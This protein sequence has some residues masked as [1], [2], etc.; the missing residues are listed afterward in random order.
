METKRRSVIKKMAASLL[1]LTGLGM[2]SDSKADS[3]ESKAAPK[4]TESFNIIQS[5][6]IPLF[7]GA[8]RHGNLV[9]IS[10]KGYHEPPY[11]IKHHTDEVLKL[12]QKELENAGSSMEKCLKATVYL[13]DIADYDAMNEVWRGRFGST[14]P[15][16]S[17]VAVAKGGVPGK[18]LVEV[19]VIAYI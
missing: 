13:D 8:T 12:V 19:D 3:K 15:A 11:E 4:E 17:T 6:R 5:H 16:R 14:P 7:S 9:F 2:V 1:A 10:G 18:S